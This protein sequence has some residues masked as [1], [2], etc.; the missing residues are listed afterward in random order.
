MLTAKLGAP[1]ARSAQRRL[2]GARIL[3]VMPSIPLHG[4]ERKTLTIMRH[5]REEGAD[6]LFI[7]NRDHGDLIRREVRRIGCATVDATFSHLLSV[8]RNPIKTAMVMVAWLKSAV[9]FQMIRRRYRPTHIHITNLTFFNYIWPMLLLGDERKIFAL[10]NPPDDTF[11][12]W[13]ARVNVANWQYGVGRRCDLVVCNSKF[14]EKQV[15]DFGV[16]RDKLF[17]LYTATPTRTNAVHDAPRID[18]DR[19]NV[20]YVGRISADKGVPQ[21]IDAALRIVAER[22]DADFYLVGDVK[23]R[24]PLA[25]SLIERVAKEGFA[26]RIHFLG[27][28]EDVPGVLRQCHLHICPSVGVEAFGQVVLEAKAQSLPSVVTPSGGLPETVE[29][30]QDGFV[31]ADTS[32]ESLYRGLRY[33]LDSDERRRLA[34]LKAREGLSRFSEQSFVD[35]WV[36]AYRGEHGRQ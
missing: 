33:F 25:T 3:V 2:I 30:L 9:E 14:T 23:W 5:L 28:L 26:T 18:R 27:E 15:L 13:K 19:L 21:L 8:Y 36:R 35:N 1:E 32:A 29:H 7:T 20:A 11:K 22:R 6:V 16:A 24:N 31:C 17:L 34:G 10:P 4:M 12:G